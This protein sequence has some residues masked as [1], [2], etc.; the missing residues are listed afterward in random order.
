MANKEL[1]QWIIETLQAPNIGSHQE[2]R[3]GNTR[4][5]ADFLWTYP[6]GKAIIIEDK[7][8]GDSS[9]DNATEQVF[10]YSDILKDEGYDDIIQIAIKDNNGIKEVRQYRN[11]QFQSNS[12]ESFIFY[13]QK[14]GAKPVVDLANDIYIYI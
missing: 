3:V 11:K 8:S 12:L 6:S 1:K 5:K 14:L 4:Q 2:V 9:I 10:R 7:E 13:E